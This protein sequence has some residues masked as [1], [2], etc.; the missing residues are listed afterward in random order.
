MEKGSWDLLAKSG[1]QGKHIKLNKSQINIHLS[2]IKVDIREINLGKI[3]IFGY[4]DYIKITL[5]MLTTNTYPKIRILPKF[6]SRISTLI[7]ERWIL[8][9]L[10][11]SLICFPC[12]PLFDI[13]S[14]L[15]FS[16]LL[17][18][19]SFTTGFFFSLKS[20]LFLQKCQCK[21]SFCLQVW[22]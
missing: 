13:K 18:V 17:P 11:L 7:L 16:I 12:K 4:S 19:L 22:R 15:P 5:K 14:Q 3:L 21:H 9:W 20:L 1:L 2:K 8:I 10:L 6:I